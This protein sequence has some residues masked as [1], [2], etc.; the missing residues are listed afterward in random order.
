MLLERGNRGWI[1]ACGALLVAATA[2]Y[3]PYALHHPHGPAGGTTLGLIYGIAGTAMMVFALLLAVRKRLRWAR[4]GRAY[5]WTQGH[6]WLGMLSYPIIL[7]HAGFRFNGSPV[8]M[9][10]M[11]LFTVVFFSGIIGLIAQERLPGR[12]VREVPGESIYEQ[13][14]HV[15]TQI[16]SNAA[17]LMDSLRK[18]PEGAVSAGGVATAIMR[19]VE[20]VAEVEAFYKK[21]IEPYLRDTVP[22]RTP[23]V[24]AE[25]TIGEFR[26]LRQRLPAEFEQPLDQLQAMVDERRQ[27]AMQQKLYR[28]LHV[29]LFVH[30]P[31]SYALMILAAVHIV[32]ASKF[33]ISK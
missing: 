19:T 30:V 4:V 22:A 23:L 21:T 26:R 2:A 13:I 16:R 8:G 7:F 32:V 6:V 28:R 20:D 17:A 31:L 24:T 11:I 3:V 1:V 27:L 15:L 5:H 33:G 9:V 10:L 12:L 29:W 25:S 18:E 14:P